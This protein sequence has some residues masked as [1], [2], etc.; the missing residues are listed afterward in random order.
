M[1]AKEETKGHMEKA[2]E[3]AMAERRHHTARHM[4]KAAMAEE[5]P[6]GA[7]AEKGKSWTL[8]H[9]AGKEMRTHLGC[10]AHGNP[11]QGWPAWAMASKEAGT[12]HDR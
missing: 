12:H 3:K 2:M 8:M 10:K 9:G 6:N 1:E 4:E 11:I 5:R 7:R